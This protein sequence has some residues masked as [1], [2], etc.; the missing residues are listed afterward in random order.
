LRPRPFFA[1]VP[2]LAVPASTHRSQT[3]RTTGSSPTA[4]S[5]DSR[6]ERS[7]IAVRVPKPTDGGRTYSF[8]VRSGIRYSN[9]ALV[10]PSDF[11][12]SLERLLTMNRG[13]ATAF[14]E[15]VGASACARGAGR[16]DLSRGMEADDRAG[17]VTIHLTGAD[18][19]FLHKLAGL[20]AVPTGTP[21][22]RGRERP[23]PGTGPYRIAA[24]GPVEVRLTRNPYFR[25][26]S[27]DARPDGYPDEIRF[28]FSDDASVRLG[29]MRR[30]EAD[31]VASLPAGGLKG[32]LARFGS[33][34]H[35][36]PTPSTDFM[37]LNTRVPPFDDVR[38]RRA[39]NY[40]V[41]RRRIV[42]LAGGPL[43]AQPACQLLPPTV[44][45]Y[46]PSCRYTLAPNE[47]GTW[48][49]PDLAKARALVGASGTRG[50]RVEVFAYEAGGRLERVDYARYFAKLLRR[51]GY[52]S[53]VRVISSIPGY[54]D[55]V[56]D[57]RNRVQIGTTGWFVDTPE[58]FLRGLFSCPSF[59]TADRLN[60]NVSEFCNPRI[61]ARMAA[62]A[63]LQASDPVRARMLWTKVDEA[64]TD[65]AVAVP[66]VHRSAVALVSERVGNYQYHPQLG[67]LFDQL[68][69]E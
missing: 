5:Q 32:L 4:A 26:W 6:A 35:T 42:E 65:R 9:G 66:L 44:P 54:F 25:L 8:R 43:V 62:A 49:A 13:Q 28:H 1:P 68:W 41:D 14:D 19:D 58:S 39:L 48:I 15:I 51:L 46:G 12:S 27:P 64:L 53:S 30:G 16:C 31:W 3:S 60:R 63:A 61:D 37:F 23:V 50:M 57:S 34:V 17:R 52:R 59:R 29:A 56:G 67:T 18:P 21:I 47:A 22:Q 7:D 38:V 45:G 10:R 2:I 40:A 11:R 24:V 20:A 33:R 55:Y 36:D 69:V